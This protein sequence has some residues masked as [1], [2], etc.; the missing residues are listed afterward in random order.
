MSGCCAFL[1]PTLY[2][3][4]GLPPLEAI[5]YGT[6]VV[7]SDT[8]CMHEVYEDV[9]YYVDPH[10]PDIDLEALLIE[11]V[12][13]PQR[14]LDKYRWQKSAEEFYAILHGLTL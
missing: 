13:D 11:S 7:V 8:P 1:F 10:K 6:R 3:G 2:E 4:F 9:A 14:I 5:S 12:G